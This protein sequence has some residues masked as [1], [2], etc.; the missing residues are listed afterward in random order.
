MNSLQ[1]RGAATRTGW[2]PPANMSFEEWCAAGEQLGQ[3]DRAVQWWIGDWWNFG[4]HRYGERA[5]IVRSL[6]WTGPSFQTCM[7]CGWVANKFKT[8][9]RNEV[10]TFKHYRAV[11]SLDLS[12]AKTLLRAAEVNRW[13]AQRLRTMVKQRRRADRET[14]LGTE[15][16]Q[17]APSTYGV[18]YADPPW[19]FEPW[20][21]ET[22][23]DRAADN[24]YPTMTIGLLQDLAVPAARN[25]V[26]FLWVTV[27]M[28]RY[29]HEVMDAW[30]FDY[31]SHCVWRKDRPGTG[32][33]FI[34][35]HE[36]LLVGV[37]GDIP[38][39]APGTQ[40]RSVIDAPVGRHS[41]K[42]AVFAEMIERHYPTLPRLEMFAR[43]PVRPG[44]DVWGNEADEAAE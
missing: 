16:R 13:S 38:A 3:M 44:W 30:G 2:T 1:L 43:G 10:L 12:Q 32:Y 25:C 34:N 21:R 41:E 19:R 11:A 15:I 5:A 27:P 14:A 18:I 42:P 36:P 26:L 22:G 40:F 31:R 7:D 24:H 33:W 35:E 28:L 29:G 9:S 20:S 8:S 39:P 23:M 4:E 6:G 17:F 37:K